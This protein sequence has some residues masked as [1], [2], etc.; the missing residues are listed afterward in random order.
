M[1]EM[2]ISPII[3]P[4][5]H[6][7]TASPYQHGHSGGEIRLSS[8]IGPM[9]G[10]PGRLPAPGS[11]RP[12]RARISAYGSSN[13][14]FAT[15]RHT[16]W[17]AIAGGRGYTASIWLKQSQVIVRSRLRRDNQYRQIRCIRQRNADNDELLP[18][19]P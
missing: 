19:I 6:P 3:G 8:I 17:T 11:H 13:H 9:L 2:G 18:V 15:S 14:G 16:E 12:V 4:S 1:G 7:F 5:L 10:D